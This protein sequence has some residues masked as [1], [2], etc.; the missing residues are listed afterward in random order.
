MTLHLQPGLPQAS[1]RELSRRLAKAPFRILP[2]NPIGITSRKSSPP[3]IPSI[4]PPPQHRQNDCCVEGRWHDVR[5]TLPPSLQCP[6]CSN[7]PSPSA[8]ARSRPAKVP[9]N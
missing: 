3:H 8:V 5:P 6:N 9:G 2:L 4:P 7:C 1:T